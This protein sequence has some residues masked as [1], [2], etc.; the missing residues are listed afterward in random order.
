VAV[1]QDAGQQ[2]DGDQQG[3]G[4]PSSDD[5]ADGARFGG[6]DVGGQARGGADHEGGPGQP[7]GPAAGPPVGEQDQRR[8]D[9]DAVNRERERVGVPA[10]VDRRY[11]QHWRLDT[12]PAG[13]DCGTHDHSC[14]GDSETVGSAE[15]EICGIPV[16]IEV[17]QPQEGAALE[18]KACIGEGLNVGADVRKDIVTL[19]RLR[20]E[21]LVVSTLG[22]EDPWDHAATTASSSDGR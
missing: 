11:L 18:D 17:A 12:R 1:L 19:D 3:E 15:V 20:R 8:D 14:I 6:G 16:V 9:L 4:W 7:A 10:G 22:D 13:V 5:P 21:L 2:L